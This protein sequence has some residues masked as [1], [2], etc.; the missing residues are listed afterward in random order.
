MRLSKLCQLR[1][2]NYHVIAEWI[3]TEINQGNILQKADAN[4]MHSFNYHVVMCSVTC[5]TCRSA[6]LKCRATCSL[7]INVLS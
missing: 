7:Y 5:E 4:F 6:I 3:R 1:T 2:H